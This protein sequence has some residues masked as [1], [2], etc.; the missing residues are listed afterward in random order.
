MIPLV[1]LAGPMSGL[2]DYNYPAFAEAAQRM[3]RAGFLVVN[4]AENGL[5]ASA[6]W[7]SHMRQD[8]HAMLDC[9]GVAL[10]PG[11]EASKGAQLEVTIARALSMQVRTVGEW[12]NE[13]KT[14]TT[15]P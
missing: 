9:Q 12:M 15:T 8:L 2:P 11:W 3:R 4:P 6:P 7:E 5:P 13:P 1:Y 10:L 14:S